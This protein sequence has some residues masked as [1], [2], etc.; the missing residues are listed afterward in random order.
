MLS[1]AGRGSVGVRVVGVIVVVG[2]GFRRGA[3][4]A[5]VWRAAWM[6]L[7]EMLVEDRLEGEALAADMAMEGLVSCVLA[8]V[9]LQLVLARVLLSTHAAHKWRDAHVKP[10]VTIEAA[11]LVKG[12]AAV[13]TGEARVIA[14]PAITHLLTQILL[15]PSHIKHSCF[16]SLQSTKSNMLKSTF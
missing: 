5:L 3:M 14:E 10:H 11:L 2:G 13:D 6:V 1:A 15:V 8:D 12:L 7:A 9:V 16:L 4:R